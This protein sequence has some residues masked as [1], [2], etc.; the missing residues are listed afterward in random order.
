MGVG[1]GVGGSVVAKTPVLR[2]VRDG[3]SADGVGGAAGA[4]VGTG[5]IG[6]V[7]TGGAVGTSGVTTPTES[8]SPVVT[9]ISGDGAVDGVDDGGVWVTTEG[10]VGGECVGLMVRTAPEGSGS[11]W[12]VLRATKATWS[13]RSRGHTPILPWRNETCITHSSAQ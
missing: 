3:D 9:T 6:G 8:L 12:A 13:S 2:V 7:T 5:R 1:S 11:V 10:D 4:L